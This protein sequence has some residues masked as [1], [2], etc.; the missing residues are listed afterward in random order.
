MLQSYCYISWTQ[1][2]SAGNRHIHAPGNPRN[3]TGIG[4]LGTRHIAHTYKTTVGVKN[5]DERDQNFKRSLPA[6]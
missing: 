3:G 2:Y 5:E 6:H 1:Y 4:T